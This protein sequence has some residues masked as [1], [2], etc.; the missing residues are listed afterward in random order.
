MY[1]I[2]P[3]GLKSAGS[4]YDEITETK[5]YT[6]VGS[7]DLGTL[8]WIYSNG[9][10]FAVLND[11]YAV[12]AYL[13]NLVCSKYATSSASSYVNLA[14]KEIIGVRG[15]Q[16]SGK[17]SLLIKDTSYTDATTFKQAMTDQNVKLYYELAT[18]I[19]T[20]V[21]LDFGYNV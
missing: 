1:D 10:F 2:F 7:V 18:P 16:Q 13:Y 5:A 11:A 15:Y 14:D 21:N 8:N 9:V 6:R 19:E 4:V 12:N 17:T 20:D 3:D